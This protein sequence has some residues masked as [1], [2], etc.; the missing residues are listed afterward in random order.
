MITRADFAQI[1]KEVIESLEEAFDYLKTNCVDHNYILFLADGEYK[2]QYENSYLK[3]NPFT[4]DNREDRYK[5]QSRLNFFIQF[6][7][8]SY[9]FPTSVNQTDDNEF[10]LTMELMIYTHIWESKPFLKQLYRLAS[11]TVG[12][13]YQ[14]EV[15]VP[16]KS[17]HK[18][19]R[20]EI[21]DNLKSK[22]LKL[23][24][25]IS[26]GFLTSLRNAFA[27]SEYQFDDNNKMIH[28]DT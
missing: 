18:Y 11:L 13:P 3:L 16:E 6:M 19:I 10:R 2:Q 4:I 5:D 21:R 14:W 27:H 28:L 23:E 22:K 1:D 12:K 24:T 20:E 25:V 26:K 9:S 17:K 15:V 8:S 7:K